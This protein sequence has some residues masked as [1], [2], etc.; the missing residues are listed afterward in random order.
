MSGK[1][2]SRWLYNGT[3]SEDRPGDLGYYVGYKITEAYYNRAADKRQAV[4][5]ILEIKD[6]DR[7]P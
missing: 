2:I 4:R 3:E 7:F 1:D 6:F 5:E